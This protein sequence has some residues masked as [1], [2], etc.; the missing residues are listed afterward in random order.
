M[1]L[2]APPTVV[3]IHL[4]L[5]RA[6]NSAPGVEGLEYRHLQAL[7]PDSFLM[8]SIFTAVWRISIPSIWTLAR[9]VP[10][11]KKVDTRDYSNFRP[12]SLLLTIYKIITG[13]LSQRL[14]SVAVTLLMALS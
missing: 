4:K 9:T 12:I 2:G 1:L 10:I 7:D 14:T 8:Q 11:Y 6:S 3:E 13:I 5:K